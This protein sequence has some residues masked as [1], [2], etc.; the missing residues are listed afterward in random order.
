M[1]L[2]FCSHLDKSVSERF[3]TSGCYIKSCL[4]N[5]MLSDSRADLSVSSTNQSALPDYQK[6]LK[7]WASFHKDLDFFV[8]GSKNWQHLKSHSLW[9]DDINKESLQLYLLKYI[10]IYIYIYIVCVYVCV[11]MRVHVYINVC[12]CVYMIQWVSKNVLDQI[13][14]KW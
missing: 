14:N 10:Y 6:Y 4:S 1:R 13:I 9:L 8:P 7:R 5:D 3:T 2:F 11:C 12:V